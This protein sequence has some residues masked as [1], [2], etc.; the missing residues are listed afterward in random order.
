MQDAGFPLTIGVY[1]NFT[2]RGRFSE[3]HVFNLDMLAVSFRRESDKMRSAR[4]IVRVPQLRGPS[5]L[6]ALGW[7]DWTRYSAL[8]ASGEV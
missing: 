6:A 4:Q 1:Q 8:V 2:V 5:K 7:T 3:L